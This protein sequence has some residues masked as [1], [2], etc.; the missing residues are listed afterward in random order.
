MRT[1][2][3]GN[4]VQ[5]NHVIKQ[6]ILVINDGRIEFIGKEHEY[7]PDGHER[8]I[9]YSDHFI[10]PGF[11]DVHIHG[12]AGFDVMDATPKALH[13]I[14]QSLSRYGVT[15]FLATTMTAPMKYIHRALQNIISFQE[16]ANEF[17]QVLGIHLEGPWINKKHKGAQKE[18]DIIDPTLEQ[19][20]DIWKITGDQLKF[21]TIAPEI[22]GALEAIKVLTN[23]GVICSIGH[24]DA[25]LEDVNQ[26]AQCGATHFTH[27]Y[28]AMRGLH[29][30][31]VGV[32]GAAF[33]KEEMTCEIIADFVHSHPKAVELAYRIKG[34]DK[35]LLISDGMRA[36][37]MRDGKYELGGQTVLVQKC[38]ARLE[39]GTLAGSTLTLDRAVKN[40]IEG[41]QTPI[42]DAIYM[43]STAPAQK[44]GISATKGSLEVG[45]DADLVILSNTFDVR[46]TMIQ[47]KEVYREA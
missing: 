2:L 3:K 20:E 6:G 9:D 4:V 34:R 35:L 29:H 32:V 42:T 1:V 31:E 45:K 27:L 15:G 26:A 46:L 43:A 24:T 7:T 21:V 30:R 39:D 33:T 12:N 17:T 10:C 19:I 36:V 23:K 28:N 44:L 11:I 25:T 38:I 37:G 16:T 8:W 14:T 22:S 13:E 41:L 47:G 5:R 40:L 18:E